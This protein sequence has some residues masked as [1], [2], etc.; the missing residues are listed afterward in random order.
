MEVLLL[1]VIWALHCQIST[2]LKY[3]N[4]KNSMQATIMKVV[5][6]FLT[7]TYFM[8]SDFQTLSNP[9]VFNPNMNPNSCSEFPDDIVKDSFPSSF[10]H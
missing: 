7:T 6:G 1:K 8:L 9:K 4:E 10:Q 3:H 5:F 2:Q